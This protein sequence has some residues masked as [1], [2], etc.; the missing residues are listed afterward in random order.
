MKNPHHPI[1][2]PP[3]L[4][5]DSC[6]A[7]MQLAN[8][9]HLTQRATTGEEGELFRA[10]NGVAQEKCAAPPRYQASD[11]DLPGIFWPREQ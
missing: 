7:A 9:R 5:E 10:D 8:E 6:I 2:R 1:F 4:S 3:Y 11:D